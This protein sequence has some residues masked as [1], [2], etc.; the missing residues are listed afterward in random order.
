MT[1]TSK[2][3]AIVTPLTQALAEGKLTRDQLKDFMQRSDGPGLRRV[4]LWL[5]MLAC[6]TT[7]VVLAWDS[8]LIWPA[9]FVQGVILVHHFSLQHECVHYTVFRTRWLNDV[10]GQICGYT[11]LLPHRFFRYEHCDHHTYTQVTGEDPEQIPMP[12]SFGAYFLYLSALP[13]WK[14]KFT[15]VFR[16][17]S[18]GLSEAERGFIPKEEWAAVARDARLM[19]GF[20]AVVIAGMAVTGW[21]GLVWLWLIPLILGEPVMRFIRMTEH[22][23]R[24]TVPQMSDNTRTNLVSAPM[25]F[26]CW[27]MNYHAE[28]HYVSSVPFHALPRLH[29]TLKDHIHVEPGGYIGAHRDI[30]RQI[31]ANNAA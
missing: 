4:A 2:T 12:T 16:H 7:L 19:L 9:M 8:W 30:W 17:A 26:L 29:E 15:E 6:S 24:P 18:G 3:S 21:W 5:V 10:V 23:G 25:R 27:N 28:H 20:Y 1:Q 22:V 31:R 13:Y 11:I 14:T